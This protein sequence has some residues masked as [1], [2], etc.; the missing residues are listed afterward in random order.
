MNDCL[1]PPMGQVLSLGAGDTAKQSCFLGICT[2]SFD[3]HTLDYRVKRAW[4]LLGPYDEDAVTTGEVAS[5]VER[6]RC[7]TQPLMPHPWKGAN[8]CFIQHILIECLQ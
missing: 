4:K 7:R 8:N 5:G 6:K 3:T 2:P 1:A